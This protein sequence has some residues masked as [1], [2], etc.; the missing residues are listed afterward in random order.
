MKGFEERFVDFPD[1]ILK[2]TEEIWEGRQIASLQRYYSPDIVVRTP[3]GVSRGNAVVI[4]STLETL[5][6]FPDRVLLGEDVIWSGDDERGMLSSHR[7]VSLATHL[8]DG[9]FG[10][11]SGKAVTFRTIA[12]CHA[13]NN[14]IDD[15]WLV[16]DT[17]AIIRQIGM[18]P[19]DFVTQ[20]SPDL[21]D[22]TDSRAFFRSEVDVPGP[23]LS[24]GNEDPWGIRYAQ[25]LRRL[26][27][28]ELEAIRQ[29]YDRAVEL[30]YPGGVIGHGHSFADRFWIALRASFPTAKFSIHQRI[31]RNDEG[32][33][34]RAAL[35]FALEGIHEGHGYFGEPTGRPAYVMGAAQ[36]EFGPRGI[37]RE[38]VVFDEVAIWRQLLR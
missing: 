25:T 28:A 7:I 5:A 19:R 29:E 6:E 21:L 3:Q 24:G 38:W 23:A 32:G 16:R 30:S 34:P 27:S 13:I 9:H 18:T 36:A 31:G 26:M 4:A 10:P 12:N 35:L 8:G 37:R 11:A 2:I 15:E 22:A 1:Y 33:P 17:G 20:S 14:V